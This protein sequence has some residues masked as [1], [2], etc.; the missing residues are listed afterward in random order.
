M[1]GDDQETEPLM[2]LSHEM[3]TD[4]DDRLGVIFV[5]TPHQ[6][7]ILRLRGR[8]A[9]QCELLSGWRKQLSDLGDD[10]YL[11]TALVELADLRVDDP[12]HDVDDLLEE[13]CERRVGRRS[14]RSITPAL[15]VREAAMRSPEMRRGL[16]TSRTRLAQCWSRLMHSAT[17][18]G[19]S[20][21]VPGYW[22]WSGTSPAQVPR[23]SWREGFLKRR[24]THSLLLAST[25]RECTP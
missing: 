13:A 23:C 8:R 12:S 5:W 15:S 24:E 14:T 9:R 21:I 11:S 25:P 1:A 16:S 20:S 6:L 10:A 7:R 4:F 18:H 19:L 22:T 2:S 17:G 3:L